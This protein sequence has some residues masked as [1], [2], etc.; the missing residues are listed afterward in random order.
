MYQ[1]IVRLL[2]SEPGASLPTQGSGFKRITQMCICIYIYI[3]I[4][5]QTDR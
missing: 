1:A 4:A 5:R 3:Y 2:L